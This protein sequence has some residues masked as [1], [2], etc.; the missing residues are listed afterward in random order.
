MT[1][2]EIATKLIKEGTEA[3]LNGVLPRVFKYNLIN[4][5]IP[6]SL[7]TKI[8]DF[9]VKEANQF[10]HYKIGGENCKENKAQRY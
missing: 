8:V 9:A 4:K 6:E 10:S 1:A 3:L 2:Q 7:A 5:G